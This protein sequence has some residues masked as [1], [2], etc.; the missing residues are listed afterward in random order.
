MQLFTKIFLS[1]LFIKERLT[2]YV[3]NWLF[4]LF[5]KIVFKSFLIVVHH[6]K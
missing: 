1:L 2:T 4:Q 5:I 3:V 6:I